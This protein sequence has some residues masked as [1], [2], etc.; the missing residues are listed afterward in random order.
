MKSM[1]EVDVYDVYDVDDV[2]VDDDWVDIKK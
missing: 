1:I 2:D